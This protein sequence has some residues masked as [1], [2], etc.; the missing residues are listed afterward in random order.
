MVRVPDQEDAFDGVE[1]VAGEARQGVNGGGRA[2]R[3]AFQDEAFVGVAAEGGGDFVDDVGCAGG[4]VLGEGGGVDCV[5][6]LSRWGQLGNGVAG[7]WEAERGGTY[8][9][10]TAELALDVGVHGAEAGGLAL[11]FACAAGVDDRCTSLAVFGSKDPV[12]LG[13][14][15]HTIAGASGLTL[16]Y[17]CS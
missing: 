8:D 12:G 4:G 5:V 15:G 6:L 7:I 10:P 17:G 13:R 2:L 1:G 11:G 9:L 3:V 16:L 14:V